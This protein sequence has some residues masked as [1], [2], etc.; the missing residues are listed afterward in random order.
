MLGLAI[1][2]NVYVF[3]FCHDDTILTRAKN[4]IFTFARKLPFVQG[5]VSILPCAL[6][7]RHR[8]LCTADF[9]SH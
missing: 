5:Q 2:Y 4:A 8:R 9:A 3:L 6:G 7:P 1:V